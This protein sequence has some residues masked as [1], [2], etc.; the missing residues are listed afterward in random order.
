MLRCVACCRDCGQGPDRETVKR[1]CL[2]TTQD[3]SEQQFDSPSGSSSQCNE[4]HFSDD[5]LRATVIDEPV[6]VNSL[7][8]AETDVTGAGTTTTVAARKDLRGMNCPSDLATNADEGPVQPKLQKFPPTNFGLQNRCFSASYY[9]RFPF[10]EYSV[11]RDAVF[12]FYCRLFPSSA[13]EAA[14]TREGFNKWKDLG[15]SLSKHARSCSHADASAKWSAWR[16]TRLSSKPVIEQL[17]RHAKTIV[18]QN[19]SAIGTLAKIA[20]VCA[21]QD[22]GLRGSCEKSCDDTD[23]TK[24]RGNF[25]ELLDL[26]KSESS[27]VK[28]QIDR[29]PQNA[30]YSSKD[31]Q[32]EL[33]ACAANVIK[34]KII[35]EVN[36]AGMYAVIVDEAR[37]ISKTEQMSVCLRYVDGHDVKERFL[38]FVTLRNDLCAAALA[39]AIAGSLQSS[40]LDLKLCVSQCYDGAS[41]M[42]GE[43][44][45]VQAQF[46]EMSGSPC[47]YVHCYAHRV[48]LALV[49]TCFSVEAAGDCIGL[50][51]AIHN[52]VTISSVRHDKFVEFQQQRNERVMELPLQ[53]D[54]RWVCKLKAI[55]TFKTRFKAVVLT[56]HFFC[57]FWKAS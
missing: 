38:N 17:D 29:L 53:S 10:V 48:N 16:Q 55:T 42:S 32:N 3:A 54:T 19:R 57:T 4:L 1:T 36:N 23:N 50:L 37:D 52:F 43:F 44:N 31:S 6:T 21:R 7:S 39:T 20:I 28:S 30:R 56:L 2:S 18:E 14:F 33:L 9:T 34:Q 35:G 40:G 15:E 41:V 25:L 51:Q 13:S 47:I 49:D 24:N 22:I 12:C 46:R 11:E 5:N 27:S 8:V 45:G 26:I